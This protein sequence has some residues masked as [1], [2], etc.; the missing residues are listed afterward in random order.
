MAVHPDVGGFREAQRR[1][2]AELGVFA[3]F[4]I[5]GDPS[6]PPG[7]PLDPETG[8]PHDPFLEPTVPPVDREEIVNCSFVHRPLVALDPAAT[9]IGAADQGLAALI[10]DEAD[11]E[12]IKDAT[13]VQ[14]G[15][16]I[17]D[18][19]RFRHDVAIRTERY[20]AYLEHA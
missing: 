20:I 14:I 17:Y 5:P 11:Y 19:Q 3:T 13:R 10:I 16:E 1:L 6:W 18:V 7:T 8:K 9:P 12:R 15:P 4:T 2:R